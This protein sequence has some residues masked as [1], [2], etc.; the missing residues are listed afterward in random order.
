M[1]NADLIS[2]PKVKINLYSYFR[3]IDATFSVVGTRR[4]KDSSKSLFVRV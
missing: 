4:M 2:L 1:V 3:L